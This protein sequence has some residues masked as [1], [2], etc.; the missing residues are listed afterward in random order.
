MIEPALGAQP[1]DRR[2]KA[3][4]D[5]QAAGCRQQVGQAREGALARRA[6]AGPHIGFGRA[7]LPV[8]PFQSRAVTLS[9]ARFACE[10]ADVLAGDDQ[11]AALAIDMAQHGLGGGNAVEAD[12]AFGEVHVH[13]RISFRPGSGLKGRPARQIDQS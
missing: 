13:D 10:V 4:D 9:K 7:I 2:A 3:V 1:R 5:R 12:L 11:F 6:Q 8:A